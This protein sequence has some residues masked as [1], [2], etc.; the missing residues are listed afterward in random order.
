[1]PNLLT[2]NLS[3]FFAICSSETIKQNIAASSDDGSKLRRQ[4]HPGGFRETVQ[5]G[6]FAFATGKYKKT[7]SMSFEYATF[8]LAAC[9][10]MNPEL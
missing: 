2:L 4:R 3:N 8:T 10:T 7:M 6:Q 1:M 9:A 5:S